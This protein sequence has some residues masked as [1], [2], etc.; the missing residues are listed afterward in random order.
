M[1]YFFYRALLYLLFLVLAPLALPL[2][3]T[4]AYWRQ[5]L[6]QRLGLDLPRRPQ[7]PARGFLVW[8]HAASVGEVRAANALMCAVLQM[9]P[10]LCFVVSTTT[11]RGRKL[12]RELLP[13]AA[14]C[15]LAPLDLPCIVRRVLQH[16]RP[17]LYICLETELWPV[18]LHEAGEMGVPLALLNGRLSAR[19]FRRYQRVRRV[20]RGV[21]ERFAVIVVT[22][23]ENA[24]RFQA[25]G[26]S[27]A[28]LVVEGNLKFDLVL[29]EQGEARRREY[30]ERLGLTGE[31][32]VLLCGSTHSG[33]EELLLE[34]YRQLRHKGGR[35]LV[36]ILAPRH[37]ERLA[38]LQV[39]C[40][41]EKMPNDLFSRL[42]GGKRQHELVLLDT[43]GELADLYCVG[44]Y[45]FCGGSLVARGGH[46]LLEATRWGRPVYYGPHV[47]DFQELAILLQE[48]GAGFPVADAAGLSECI[49]QHMRDPAAY[50]AACVRALA[51]T[52]SQ[53]G[54]ARR[55]AAR[56][57]ALLPDGGGKGG[58]LP[59]ASTMGQ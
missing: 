21:L 57:L 28:R 58:A 3:L 46:N 4:R 27:P 12:A 23:Q 56:A 11:E 47:E 49:L 41:R 59:T 32:P 18:M 8:L 29:D 36:L 39:L 10:G 55:Q 48:A 42:Q 13:P 44:T 1:A 53:R 5:G 6:W 19:S 51:V 22:G 17:D 2:C 7:V 38:A 14:S 43:M 50:E 31:T 37:L 25:L 33:E 9:R 24:S 54:S 30:R 16:L 15:V 52:R 45:N 20:V 35:P 40:E 34:V 26:I